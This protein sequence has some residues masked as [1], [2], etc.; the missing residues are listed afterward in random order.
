VLTA[1]S[2][3]PEPLPLTL[4]IHDAVHN[5]QYEDRFNRQI[6][7]TPGRNRIEIPLADL[8][9]AP[10]RREMDL[11]HISGI[12][13]FAYRLTDPVVIYLGPIRLE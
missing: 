7:L 6:V 9:A 10:R 1:Y 8:R 4:R 5:G 12:G 11:R 13:I 3:R 2:N